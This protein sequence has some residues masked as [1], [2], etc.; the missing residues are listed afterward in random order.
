MCSGATAAAILLRCS[1]PPLELSGRLLSALEPF[2]AAL[3]SFYALGASWLLWGHS[4]SLWVSTG[5][6]LQ[7]SVLLFVHRCASVCGSRASPGARMPPPSASVAPPLAAAL[8]DVPQTSAP[9]K[10]RRQMQQSD[11]EHEAGDAGAAQPEILL[12]NGVR[13]RGFRLFRSR[14]GTSRA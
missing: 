3:G 14:V 1:S 5:L 7:D 12:M 9:K 4:W 10:R 2:L 6:F 13:H 8:P 11:A